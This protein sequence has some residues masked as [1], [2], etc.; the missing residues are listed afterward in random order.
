MKEIAVYV[1]GPLFSSGDLVTNNRI[2]I[3]A[4][5]TLETT[6]VEGL[7]FRPFIPHIST[8]TWQLVYVRTHE[9][10]QAWD[11]HWLRKCDV[12]L[13]LPGY[14]V[15]T[16]HEVKVAQEIGIPVLPNIQSVVNWARLKLALDAHRQAATD[17]G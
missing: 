13:R 11:D 7:V 1:A 10:A 16:E 4:A 3:D 17:V 2:A 12:M 15:G 6:K 8:L 5:N 14:S 9:V